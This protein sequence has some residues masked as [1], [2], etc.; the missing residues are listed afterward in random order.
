MTAHMNAL[1]EILINQNCK[2]K[3]PKA[4]KMAIFIKKVSFLTKMSREIHT[5]AQIWLKMIPKDT[6]HDP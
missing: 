2:K 3:C 6:F 1:Q 4:S 5:N